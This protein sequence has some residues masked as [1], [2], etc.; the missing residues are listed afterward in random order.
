MRDRERRWQQRGQHQ[1][2]THMGNTMP[3]LEFDWTGV[4]NPANYGDLVRSAFGA[5]RASNEAVASHLTP[6]MR[7]L[8][9]AQ[10]EITTWCNFACREC[11]RTK[12]MAVGRW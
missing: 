3:L 8:E 4:D 2:R 9:S 12:E 10:I 11:L 5:G 1:L 6:P 7:V